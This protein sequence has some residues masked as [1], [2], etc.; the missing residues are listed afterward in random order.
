MIVKFSTT[1]PIQIYHL[2]YS[3]DSLFRKWLFLFPL[4]EKENEAKR[5]SGLAP[6]QITKKLLSPQ[7]I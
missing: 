6:D 7:I 1:K 5:V 3:L 2:I 4:T